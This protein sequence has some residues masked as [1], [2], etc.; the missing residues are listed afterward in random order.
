MIVV[1]DRPQITVESIKIQMNDGAANTNLDEQANEVGRFPYIEIGKH[2]I[3]GNQIM[4]LSLYNDQFLPRITMRFKDSSGLLLDP[5]F[6]TDNS[7]L[8]AF[9]QSSNDD[10]M[11]YVWT[12]R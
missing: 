4:V 9:I 5:L 2:V 6:P 11:P 10:L 12:L 1:Y 7:I 8:K 3:E